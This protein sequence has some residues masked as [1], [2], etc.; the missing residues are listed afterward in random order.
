MYVHVALYIE[1]Y[2]LG[3]I[4]MKILLVL[5]VY[6]CTHN[7]VYT[8]VQLQVAMGGLVHC[9]QYANKGPSIQSILLYWAS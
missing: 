6:T 2:L 1:R 8:H 7:Y 4:P 5:H 9:I 3:S